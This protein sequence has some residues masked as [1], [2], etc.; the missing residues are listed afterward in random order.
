[1]QAGGFVPGPNRFIALALGL[2]LPL[3]QAQIVL[4]GTLGSA[5]AL[6]GPNFAI[7]AALGKQVGGNLFHS[8]TK[9]NVLTGESATFSG[10]SSVTNIIGR[11]T[12]HDAS[13][14]DGALRST[15]PGANLYLLNPKGVMFGPN[16]SLDLTGSF[17]ATTADYLKLGPDGR[18]DA[19]NPGASV[20]TASPPSSFGFLGPAPAAIGV[21]GSTLEVPAQKTLG[22]VGGD[23]TLSNAFVSAPAG[24]VYL[25][26]SAS[27]GEV[28]LASGGINTAGVT[29]FGQI[30]VGSSD[31]RADSDGA[32][33]SGSIRI[34]GGKLA[35]ADTYVT[36]INSSPAKGGDISITLSGELSVSGGGIGTVAKAAGDAGAIDIQAQRLSMSSQGVI[37]ASTRGGGGSGGTIGVAAPGGVVLRSGSGI[38]VDAFN[39]GAGSAGAISIDAGA[40]KLDNSYLQATSDGSG[41][42]GSIILSA[43]KLSMSNGAVIYASG[44]DTGQGGDIRIQATA[45]LTLASGSEIRSEAYSGSGSITLEAAD[46]V[47]Q[48]ALISSATYGAGKAGTINLSA[49]NSVTVAGAAAFVYADTFSSGKASTV[50]LSGPSV[51]IRQAFLSAEGDAGAAGSVVITGNDVTITDN[52]LLYARALG[53]GRGGSVAIDAARLEIAGDSILTTGSNSSGAGG[54]VSLAASE[55]I[56]VTGGS[57]AIGASATS[58]GNAGKVAI[59]A[60]GVT[61][62]GSLI[63][64]SGGSFADGGRVSVSGDYISMSNG[65]RASAVALGPGSGGGIRVAGTRVSLDGTKLDSTNYGSGAGGSISLSGDNVSIMN[66]SRL[67]ASALG[68]APGGNISIAGAATSLDG[69]WLDTKSNGAAGNISLSGGRIAI[70]ASEVYVNGTA[71]GGKFAAAAT[72]SFSLTGGSLIFGQSSG[73]GPAGSVSISA[74]ALTIDASDVTTTAQAAGPAGPISLQGTDIMLNN[75]FVSSSSNGAGAANNIVIAASRSV[76]LNGADTLIATEL[77]S[78]GSGG[79][80]TISAPLVEMQGAGIVSSRTY[81]PAHGG[82]VTVNAER[83][84]LGDVF[85]TSTTQGTGDGGSVFLDATQSIVTNGF[86]ILVA[87]ATSTGNAGKLVLTA[88][89]IDFLTGNM[90]SSTTGDG[91]AGTI[92]VNA[93]RLQIGGLVGAPSGGPGASGAVIISAT[94]SVTILRS[95]SILNAGFGGDSGSVSIHAPQLTVFGTIFADGRDGAAGTIDIEVGQ[96]LNSGLISANS[97]GNQPG[98]AITITAAES[99][100]IPGLLTSLAFGQG[101]GGNVSITTPLLTVDGGWITTQTFGGGAAGNI[102]INAARVALSNGGALEASTFG[103]G[104]AGTISLVAGNSLTL[105]GGSRIAS[106]SFGSGNAGD[107]SINAGAELRMSGGSA[108]STEAFKADGGNIDIKASKVVYLS[109]SSITTAV[110]SGQGAGGN[111]TID[112]RLVWLES[113]DIS[114]NAFGGPGGNIRINAE[115]FLASAD[116]A[117]QASSHKSV[118]GVVTISTP[119]VDLSSS[120]TVLANDFVDPSLLLRVACSTR[121]GNT[122]LP[123]GRGGLAAQPER[124]RLVEHPVAWLGAERCRGG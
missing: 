51:V 57:T 69:A 58:S 100:S 43:S 20:F 75:A 80:I 13:S 10:P 91:A 82:D 31:I 28:A 41:A 90:S 114:A 24:H 4:D 110:G 16:A 81:G 78:T 93:G 117:V 9:F 76:S 96:L 5:G 67:W 89:V 101:A 12:G 37:D 1:M 47:V 38:L 98:G 97:N 11:V 17:Y 86:P 120:L 55:S 7:G 68:S 95:G 25:A 48:D 77:T 34:V 64:A 21:N 71:S 85:I 6:A 122:F 112:P 39:A 83:L 99:A 63:A 32:T 79:G 61:I 22:L 103:A 35:L 23:L 84:S 52:A 42:A 66:D 30:S 40:L 108:I 116:S 49:S 106:A 124:P 14:I 3:G 2:Y 88:P 60:P 29:R 73:N 33:P 18:F 118:P 46:I 107:I 72:E 111:I 121:G 87:D 70:N 62:D 65:A 109:D 56:T 26:S 36:A 94:E 44:Y 105:D 104:D 8:F 53:A 115:L 15:I 27:A 59:W 74:P 113:S 92:L 102:R 123:A 19:A 45:P 54:S 50:S 119:K